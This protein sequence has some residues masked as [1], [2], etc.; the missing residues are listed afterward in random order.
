MRNDISSDRDF[1][2]EK[3][4]NVKEMSKVQIMYGK[5]T[6]TLHLICLL[7]CAILSIKRII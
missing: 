2:T 6:F 3:K 7:W 4:S 1:V 5:H